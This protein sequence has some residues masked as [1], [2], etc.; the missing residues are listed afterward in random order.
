MGGKVHYYNLSAMY[1]S[2][3]NSLKGNKREKLLINFKNT[4]ELANWMNFDFALTS[5]MRKDRT[6]LSFEDVTEK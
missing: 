1:S 3:E 2:D 5:E 6:G 4:F